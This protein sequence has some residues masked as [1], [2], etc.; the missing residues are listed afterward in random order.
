[1][2]VLSQSELWPIAFT[3]DATH[4]GPCCCPSSVELRGNDVIVPA[5]PIVPYDEDGGA[6]PKR[7]LA[8]RVHDGRDP[9]GPV[10]LSELG[11]A[12]GERRDRT[13]RPN[14]PIRRRWRCC[15]KASSGR[16]RS[17]RTRPTRARAVVRAR[18]SCGGTT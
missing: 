14:R 10:L 13:S 18:S 1:M 4:S 17:R 16:S 6:V 15:P 11:R 2:A 9:L 3:T 5:A 7:A 12:A 8:D